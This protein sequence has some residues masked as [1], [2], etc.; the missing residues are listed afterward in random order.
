MTSTLLKETFDEA[1]VQQLIDLVC[2]RVLTGLTALSLPMKYVGACWPSRSLLSIAKA[3]NSP[4]ATPWRIQCIYA[5][6]LRPSHLRAP[7]LMVALQC[8]A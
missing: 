8:R 3:T 1:R 7:T 6:M 4:R 2:E 5:I